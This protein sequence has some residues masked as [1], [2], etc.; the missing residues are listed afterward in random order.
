M[1][2]GLCYSCMPLDSFLWWPGSEVFE[3]PYR[4]PCEGQGRYEKRF[5][6][7]VGFN[8][9]DSIQGLQDLDINNDHLL[10]HPGAC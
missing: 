10:V 3:N 1:V 2:S 7:H 4:F 9:V 6:R 8:F 5:T